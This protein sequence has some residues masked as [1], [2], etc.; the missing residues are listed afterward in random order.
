MNQVD[1]SMYNWGRSGGG[2]LGQLLGLVQGIYGMGSTVRQQQE[3]R[4]LRDASNYM[5]EVYGRNMAGWNGVDQEDYAAR[6]QRAMSEIL[7]SKP[8]Y[9]KYAEPQN[10]ARQK[11]QGEM[12]LQQQ[13][14]QGKQLENIGKGY[15]VEEKQLKNHETFLKLQQMKTNAIAEQLADVSDEQSYSNAIMALKSFGIDTSLPDY[16]TFAQ[17]PTGFYDRIEAEKSKNARALEATKLQQEKYNEKKKK[18]ESEYLPEEKRLG[19]EKLK[20][21]IENTNI[22]GVPNQAF[23]RENQL[24]NSYT[25]QSR[26]YNDVRNSF[27]RISSI[28]GT[29]PS[30]AGDLSL[31]FNYMKM[32]DPG[33]VVRESEFANAASA[34][35]YGDRIQAA[36]LRVMKG[37]RLNEDMRNDFYSR[38]QTLYKKTYDIQMNVANQ[39]RGIA[40]DYGIDPERV[41]GSIYAE[42]PGGRQQTQQYGNQ[43]PPP[44]ASE[45]AQRQ[46]YQQPAQTDRANQLRAKYGY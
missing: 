44:T 28:Y 3:E 7:S 2:G 29:P 41:V 33:S 20:K 18:I 15:D 25:Q 23:Q 42:E 37:Q 46:R 22:G 36:V 12:A 17:N 4:K 8:E 24:R 10:R 16:Q 35:A 40:Q 30:A 14:I 1:T 21:E 19:I 6:N 32:L 31:I 34:G 39:Y 38:A 9:F 26:E 27:G 13:N 43:P 45:A 11:F 5:S